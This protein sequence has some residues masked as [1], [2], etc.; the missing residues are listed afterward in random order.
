MFEKTP[1]R[2]IG[3]PRPILLTLMLICGAALAW[4]AKDYYSGSAARIRGK[5]KPC[6]EGLVDDMEHSSD[7]SL[8]KCEGRSGNWYNFFDEGTET[9]QEF[10]QNASP[11]A[12]GRGHAVRCNGACENNKR[13]DK[14]WGAGFGFDLN[15]PSNDPKGKQGYDAS[16]RGYR[17]LRFK[18]RLGDTTGATTVVSVRFTDI[19]T[20]PVGGRCKT[21]WDD[22]SYAINLGPQWRSYTIYWNDLVHVGNGVPN[23]PFASD[24]IFSVHW[25]FYPSDAYDIFVDDVEFVR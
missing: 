6:P 19:N 18:A 23:A 12:L 22:Y 3:L 4:G 9:I 15:N 5:I 11:G 1:N 13:T 24:A 20:D 10:Q 2:G 21:C 17:G 16:G 14:I 7:G 25:R 8:P